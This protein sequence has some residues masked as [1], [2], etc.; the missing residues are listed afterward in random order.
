MK[1]FLMTQRFTFTLVPV[2]GGF[3]CLAAGAYP[4]GLLAAMG[5]ITSTFSQTH[6]QM[7]NMLVMFM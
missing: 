5:N 7:L 3:H 6:A 2:L 4:Y 1:T